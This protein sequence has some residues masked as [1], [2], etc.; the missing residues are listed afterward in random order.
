MQIRPMTEADLDGATEIDGTIHSLRYLHLDEQGEGA[1]R[2]WKL[3]DRPRREKLVRSN[4]LSDDLRFELKQIVLGAAE[5]GALVAEHDDEILGLLVQRIDPQ[6]RLMRIL[7]VRVDFDARRQGIGSAMVFQAVREAREQS[8]R[9]VSIE[10]LT[11]NAPAYDFL[12]R[13]G[14]ELAGIDS[15][16]L[17]N[18]DLVKESVTLFW[19]APLE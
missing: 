15:R 12:L 18:H 13:C 5:G 9:A 14:F 17:S 19:Y 3:D 10:T 6:T 2:S 1:M 7:D 11:D 4:T 8:L 16:R